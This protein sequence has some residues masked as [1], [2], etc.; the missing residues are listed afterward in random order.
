[1]I[2]TTY[3]IAFINAAR[4]LV[5]DDGP[6][7][8]DA[9]VLLT[10]SIADRVLETADKFKEGDAS[11]VIIVT[12]SMG[13]YKSLEERG[14]KLIN[15]TNQI[16]KALVELG[17]P[18]DRITVLPGDAESTME[19]ATIIDNYLTSQTDIDTIILVS[20]KTHTRR[21]SIIFNHVLRKSGK[22]ITILCSPSR[23]TG[24]NAEKWW[25]NKE[26]I[27]DVVLEYIKL[28]SFVL[29]EKE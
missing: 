16:S 27:Q 12:E 25:T 28:A 8:G 18:S 7:H 21:A 23:Y 1:M 20:S 9:M 26:D 3:L 11:K 13:E 2:V 22:K 19:E 6:V 4:W 29:F 17:V 15:S 10:G 5:K 24:F 14:I